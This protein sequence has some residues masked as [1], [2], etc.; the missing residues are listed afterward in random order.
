MIRTRSRGAPGPIGTWISE[1]SGSHD[2]PSWYESWEFCEDVADNPGGNNP[3]DL[4]KITSDPITID[5]T[6]GNYT[7][8][9]CGIYNNFT[10]PTVSSLSNASATSKLGART[11]PHRTGVSL[12]VNF[13]ELRDLPLLVRLAGNSLLKKAASGNLAYQFGWKPILRDL[14]DLMAFQ[15]NV[16]KR[17]SE[18][19][20]LRSSGGLRRKRTLHK[21]SNSYSL[22]SYNRSPIG[23]VVY[24]KEFVQESVEQWGT[25][26]YIP[27]SLLKDPRTDLDRLARKLFLGLHTQQIASN[28]WEVLPWSWLIDWFSNIGDILEAGNGS[29]AYSNRSSIMTHRKAV[30]TVQVTSVAPGLSVNRNETTITYETKK[31]LPGASYPSFNNGFLNLSGSQASILGSLSVL[32][33]GR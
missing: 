13:V 20:Q 10:V 22:G 4:L 18:L 14:K 27:G 30:R 1:F 29:I 25:I 12:P 28:A 7:F 19:D 31:R 11:S 16:A 33:L 23:S 32:K 9:D 3:F 15:G 17:Y 26:R 6:S 8:L 2:G 21:S 5:G 24:T